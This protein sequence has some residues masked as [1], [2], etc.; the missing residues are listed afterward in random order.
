L[1]SSALE[2]VPSTS[3]T[4]SRTMESRAGVVNP[5]LTIYEYDPTDQ[6]IKSTKA[7]VDTSYG[8][9]ADGNQTHRR[10][11]RPPTSAASRGGRAARPAPSRAGA[12]REGA[13][14]PPDSAGVLQQRCADHRAEDSAEAP[15]A[16]GDAHVPAVQIGRRQVSE[17]A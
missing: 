6:L 1:C 10:R 15:G 14:A 16:R 2:H 11:P 12:R 3:P 13:G 9:D 7:G 4:T 17:R 5:G 8:Y